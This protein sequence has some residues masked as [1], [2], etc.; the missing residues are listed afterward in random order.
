M[1]KWKLP[2]WDQFMYFFFKNCNISKLNFA[3]CTLCTS[4]KSLGSQMWS[5]VVATPSTTSP[6]SSRPGSP[7]KATHLLDRVS[8]SRCLN[9]TGIKYRAVPSWRGRSYQ[10]D[11]QVSTLPLSP[12]AF[13]FDFMAANAITSI[14]KYLF[15]LN[16]PLNHSSRQ[17]RLK[18]V[19]TA[20]LCPN[21]LMCSRRK[22]LVIY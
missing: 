13:K 21:L 10:S 9:L 19:F 4:P 18:W 8:E 5:L 7:V 6:R 20:F 3:S 16:G 11:P 12:H 1:N 14:Q 17:T 22:Y 15:G 2:S